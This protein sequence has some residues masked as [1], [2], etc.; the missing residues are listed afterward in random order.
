MDFEREWN[1]DAVADRQQAHDPALEALA[2]RVKGQNI[3][4]GTMR[5]VPI[6][7][8]GT[9]VLPAGTDINDI[10]V[11]GRN[12]IVTLPDGTQM[13]ILDGAVIVPRIVVGDVEIPSV[14][15]AAL[16]IGEEPQP[17]AGPP[18]SSGGNFLAAEGDVG[19]PHGL[20]DLLPPTEL[21]FSQP[22]ERE[23]LPIAPDEDENHLPQLEVPTAGPGTVVD[24]SGLGVD[25]RPGKSPGSNEPAPIETTTGTIT[26]VALDAP[27]TITING[28]I[29]TTVG[30]TI[31]GTSGTLT[32][33]SV[34]PGSV[35]YSYTVT[36]NTSGDNVT[37][38]FT[39]TVTDA[40]GDS[41]TK[42]LVIN[43]IDDVPTAN[44][45]V[46]QQGAENAP[47]VI[48][49]FAN[50][51][52]GA[53]GVDID[54][55]P[56]VRVTIVS[57]PAEG[58]VVYNPATGLFTFTPA[59]GQEGTA[60]FVYQIQDGDGDTS[61]ATVTITLQPDS[62]PSVAVQ[63]GSDTL[64]DEAA[65]NPDGSN[66]ASN[67]ETVTGV[68][69]IA[70][71]N[72][73]VASL[74]INNV[75]VTNGG[76][77]KG[78]YGTLTVTGS[79][80][81][82]YSYS[83]TLEV[84][85]SG[86]TTQD[87]FA[88]TVTDSD[89]DAAGTTLNIGIVDDRP[90]AV[91][92]TGNVVVE[93]SATNTLSGN[94]L[95][96]DVSGA[97]T[98]KSFVSWGADAAALAEL[99]SYGTLTQNGDGS[100]SYVLDNSRAATQALGG[101]FSKDFT[102]NYTMQDADGDQSSATLTITVK[103]A[104]DSAAVVTAAATGPDAMVHEA[105]LPSGTANDGSHVTSGSFTVSAT[106]GIASITV[107]GT[108]F[109]L[110]QMQAFGTTNG[111]VNTGEGEL[112]LTGY[113][114]A[115]GAVSYSYTLL[116]T[117]DNDSKEGAT[118]TEFDDSIALSVTGVGG[119]SGSDTLI[120]RIVDDAPVAVNDAGGTLTEDVAGSLSGNVLGNDVSGADTPKSFVSWGADAAAVAE[121][122]SYGTLTQN[123]DGSWSYVL[124]NSRAATQALGG[125][126]SK[127][128]T[129]NYTMQ[130]ADGDQSS[131][132]L[133]ITVKGAD[134]SAAVVTAAATGPDAM[135]HEA[136][137]P[138][139]TANDGS[140]V[141]SGSF[142]VSATDG[143]AS[144]TVGGTSFTLAQMQA[145]GT[146]NGV[147]NTGEGELRL[148]GYNAATGAVSYSYTLLAT[149]DNDSKEGATGTEFDDSI[150][151]SVT[152]VGGT[153]GS[154]TLI[155]RIVDDAPIAVDDADS[156]TE[157]L[158]NTAD[159][160]VF[161]GI[162]GTDVNT[163]DGTADTI[164]AD[165]AAAGG[166]VTGARVGTEAGG[167]ALTS[168][169]AAG[170]VISGTYGD[171]L[172]KADGSYT[173]TLKTASIPVEVTSET[174][175]YQI[176]DGDGDTDLAQL[177]ISLNQDGRV[178]NVTGDTST[179]YEDGLADG[180]QHGPDSE[181]D[182]SGQFT[183]SANGES[184]TL[185]LDGDLNPPQT[186]TAVG[187]QVVTSKGVLTI[188]S[189]S[190]PDVN[191][192]VTYGYSYTLI[193]ALTH[194]GQGEIN[195]LTDTIS[196]T[197]TDATGDSDA[198]PGS[199][200][201]SIVDDVPTLASVT[202]LS[203]ANAI[204][205][206]TG[207]DISFTYG[208]DQGGSI[209][210][211][212]LTDIPGIIY[213]GDGTGTVTASVNGI[214]YF[215]ISVDQATGDY[216]VDVLTVRPVVDTPLSFSNI[217]PGNYTTVTLPGGQVFDGVSYA[218]GTT[219]AEAFTNDG[220]TINPSGNGFGIANNLVN[221]NEGFL[222]SNPD[223]SS[224]SFDVNFQP[225]TSSVT[226]SWA[227][228]AGGTPAGG[229]AP[230]QTGSF[231][232][233]KD[234]DGITHVDIDPTLDFDHMVVRF[235]YTGGGN[236]AVRVENFSVT[237]QVIP[238]DQVLQFAVTVQDGD[239]DTVTSATPITTIDITFQ[240]GAPIPPVAIDLDGDGLEFIDRS[241][242]VT[243]DYGAGL[244][245]TAWVSPDDGL[246]AH[247]I[248]GSYDIVFAD[249]APGAKSDLEGLR[250][251]YDG[252]GD[253]V[254]DARD[255]AYSDFG[256]WQDLNSNGVVDSGEF[257]SLADMGIASIKLT[258]DGQSYQA[259]GG[260]VTVLGEATFTRTDGTTGTVG[261]VM[262]S[263]SKVG[264]ATKTESTTSGFNQALIAASLVAVAAAAETVE[265]APVAAVAE[266]ETV[267]GA[268]PLFATSTVAEPSD[269]QDVNMS[270]LSDSQERSGADQPVAHTSHGSS[271]DAA[272]D[273]STLSGGDGAS[274]PAANDAGQAQPA[275]DDHHG[276]L[277]QT[278]DLPTFDANAAALVAV[279]EAAP[280]AAV[281]AQVVAEALDSQG[282][283]DIDA[284]LAAL[285]GGEHAPALFNPVAVEAADAGHMMAMAANVFDAAMV[286]HE[287]MAVAHG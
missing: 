262:F 237:Q 29:I 92:D 188:T 264:D 157:G 118:G 240:G 247:A 69:L 136:G 83:Y 191:G 222:F 209:T 228:Y 221:D 150:A 3:Q 28:Q 194:S 187:Q 143:I 91:D 97:D 236:P 124:D 7:A 19:D 175:T 44:D 1:V 235:D 116:A 57:G 159:G 285:P 78:S 105:G 14:N 76:T 168:V 286:A 59:A 47:V 60:S 210:L 2:A 89:G 85:T 274:A 164:G 39:V 170:T 268:D 93:D 256:V 139:G 103:G 220:S 223:S 8:D 120:V 186:I 276:L 121:L 96:N 74:I 176:T 6:G 61:Q 109:T 27:A 219:T 278:V 234:A 122:N 263:T 33:I 40:D 184:Y 189:I 241:A 151:L 166:A 258:S 177:V 114:A 155:V 63:A 79:P 185:T 261:D 140:H 16:L 146:T 218:N 172:I 215:T 67:G 115:T 181:T 245:S 129:L 106:D 34:A 161:T 52:F 153:S 24:E 70:T 251:A 246:L 88:V 13:V 50:D 81:T 26:Y 193:Q 272:A 77:V 66:A 200:V 36:D 98:P 252:N 147:V 206:Y 273:H 12:L 253:G 287:A 20:G 119:T 180:A 231:V 58:T 182:T 259:A 211:T 243:H 227:T 127:D 71:G 73:T 199:I 15:L 49:A 167:G 239:G 43:V 22:E 99:N 192:T 158:G 244:V 160:N 284:L 17:A 35:G 212:H 238:D 283:P 51:V 266:A 196:M 179:V 190:A 213:S 137:L 123:G 173:Y 80:T 178:P 149:I 42:N 86:D 281:A 134:D 75:D 224:L 154:D 84:A 233:T 54:N 270:A 183:V 132:T 111:V 104:D 254:F 257:R 195:P 108:S 62:T 45:D 229:A 165:T 207:N 56:A 174:F 198:T 230:L 217:A 10:A 280:N 208:A 38:N 214:P 279:H 30:Q 11:D 87:S 201:I 269:E 31:V 255:A 113:N 148:T 203:V 82:G 169:S 65:L 144:I 277:A 21:S 205:T 37:D 216:T 267:A 197:V 135:V 125:G 142:T 141:T 202:D 250:L 25:G 145:F 138:S 18:R 68:F 72:D 156:V 128:F 46:V 226:I 249:D 107:G 55:N 171:L 265:E 131:A 126:F 260:D 232:V 101:G 94:V 64:V 242:G 112:R 41:I 152:G 32:I 95:G 117:I 162:G 248:G 5:T 275:L 100:W 102:L 9:V 133:T 90:Q 282:G 4:P 110:A 48:N 53:D 225:N 23:I 204:F 130:D 163:T 271:D